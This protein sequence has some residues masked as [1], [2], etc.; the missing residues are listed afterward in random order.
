MSILQTV[1]DPKMD[2]GIDQYDVKRCSTLIYYLHVRDVHF[3]KCFLDNGTWVRRTF[4]VEYG[5][6][7]EFVL[8]QRKTDYL[9]RLL[10]AASNEVNLPTPRIGMFVEGQR[11][12]FHS[13]AHEDSSVA[14]F[15]RRLRTWSSSF[16]V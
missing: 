10:R 15:L 7:L 4:A 9:R 13:F 12:F 5:R 1:V 14:P 3:A 2:I 6:G 11:I 16:S 8:R